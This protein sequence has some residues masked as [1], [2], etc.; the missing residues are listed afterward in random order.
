MAYTLVI[1]QSQFAAQAMQKALQQRG[2]VVV[3]ATDFGQ[4]RKSCDNLR[5]DLVVMGDAISPRIKRALAIE[6]KEYCAEAPVLDICKSEPCIAEADYI[7]KSDSYEGLSQRIHEIL[8]H[9][10]TEKA[11]LRIAG[12]NRG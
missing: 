7:L 5:F 12:R 10:T 11:G 1:A 2:H 8:L 3:A 9:R 4:V 6:L